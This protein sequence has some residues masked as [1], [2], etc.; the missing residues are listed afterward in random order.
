MTS[1]DKSPDDRELL[2]NYLLAGLPEEEI[3][4]L[5]ELSI[6]DDEFAWRL[7][8]VENDL[9][10]A[11]V[12]GE[13]TGEIRAKFQS[14]YLSSAERREK[15]AFAEALLTIGNQPA[16]AAGRVVQS[17]VRKPNRITYLAAA[18][19]VVLA[20]ATVVL[21]FT[22]RRARE[23]NS[24]TQASAVTTPPPP[25]TTGGAKTPGEPPPPPA[26]TVAPVIFGFTVPALLTRGRDQ[27]TLSIPPGTTH[28]LLNLE[29]ESPA[30]R[31]V[32]VELRTIDMRVVWSGPGLPAGTGMLTSAQVPVERL[33]P[34]DY[35]VTVSTASPRKVELW[36]YSF[37]VASRGK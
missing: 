16:S 17:I 11:Y 30:S 14:S 26:T 36:R 25:Q 19:A 9:I 27:A 18:A 4:R 35:I 33:E 34:N 5:D 28:V 24:Q 10:D 7:R 13:L 8:D 20:V 3:E 2:R 22:T 23:Q 6:A 12:R 31:P 21:L 37:R 1:V 15:V 32:T 29:G